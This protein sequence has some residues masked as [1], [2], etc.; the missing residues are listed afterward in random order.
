MKTLRDIYFTNQIKSNLACFIALFTLAIFC[1]NMSNCRQVSVPTQGI[2]VST[3]DTQLSSGGTVKT[4]AFLSDRPVEQGH[5]EGLGGMI[6]EGARPGT[7]PAIS[8]NSNFWVVAYWGGEPS[9]NFLHFFVSETGRL[10]NRA[11]RDFTTGSSQLDNNSRPSLTFFP[12]TQKWFITFRDSTNAIQIAQF[13][14]RCVSAQGGGCEEETRIEGESIKK[15]T[16]SRIGDVTNTGLTTQRAPSL[17]FVEGTL[18]LAFIPL[19]STTLSVATST[20]GITFTSPTR[21]LVNG[22][23]ITCD[24]GAP[25]INNMLGLFL[26]TA[27]VKTVTPSSTGIDIKLFSSR[28]GINWT[29]MRT[30]DS[31]TG[32]STGTVNPAIAGPESEMLVAYRTDGQR[33]TSVRRS[34]GIGNPQSFPTDTDGSV[35]FAW[36]PPRTRP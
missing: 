16:I 18:V 25:Y 32:T 11:G 12:P 22:T 33:A 8:A 19:N 17:S 1:V 30:I 26:A 2:M 5:I 13:E 3:S 24:A 6:N 9:F 21:A 15:F 10:W 36:G 31:G 29:L 23:P 20:N 4:I 28:D 27:E 34:G 14:I 7:A 35:S